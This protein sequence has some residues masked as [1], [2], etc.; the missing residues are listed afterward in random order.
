MENPDA[1][2][3]YLAGA[4]GVFQWPAEAAFLLRA[5]IETTGLSPRKGKPTKSDKEISK[6]VRKLV[7]RQFSVDTKKIAIDAVHGIVFVKGKIST[8]WEKKQLEEAVS[9]IPDVVGIVS[10]NLDVKPGKQPDVI[11]EKSIRS[12]IKTTSDIDEKTVGLAVK[13]GVVSISGTVRDRRELD[14]IIGLIVHIKGVRDIRNLTTLS[15]SRKR[16]DRSIALRV[17]KTVEEFMPELEIDVAVFGGVAVLTGK[18]ERLSTKRELEKTVLLDPDIA[19]NRI[20]SKI[21][22]SK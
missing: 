14:R 9:R 2:K 18:V 22:I 17:Q 13:N 6:G 16:Q 19:V 10:K 8:L 7:K 4:S 3:L 15:P 20:I 11:L 1:R 21:E 12:F 5:M